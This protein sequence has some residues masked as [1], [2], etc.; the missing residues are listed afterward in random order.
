MLGGLRLKRR[1]A[2][3][4]LQIIIRGLKATA[5]LGPRYARKPGSYL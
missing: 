4:R 1:D 5:I 2:T 3:R